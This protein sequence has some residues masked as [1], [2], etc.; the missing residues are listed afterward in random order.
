[1]KKGLPPSSPDN[2]NFNPI[3]AFESEVVKD[4]FK[5]LALIVALK[6]VAKL[7]DLSLKQ[8]VEI[9]SPKHWNNVPSGLGLDEEFEAF[10]RCGSQGFISI[11]EQFDFE[12]ANKCWY[13]NHLSFRNKQIIIDADHIGFKSNQSYEKPFIKTPIYLDKSI[14]KKSINK[15]DIRKKFMSQNYE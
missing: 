12:L 7:N 1:M 11:T 5:E 14:R 2:K 4:K 10:K 3:L 9:Y 13:T 8:Q 15:K 6:E